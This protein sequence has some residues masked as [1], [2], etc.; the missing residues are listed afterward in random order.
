M[1][2]TAGFKKWIKETDSTMIV[3]TK[4]NTRAKWFN[5]VPDNMV[6]MCMVNMG[7]KLSVSTFVIISGGLDTD[8]RSCHL[9]VGVKFGSLF[10][11]TVCSLPS[12]FD[13]EHVN[14]HTITIALHIRTMFGHG[15][16]NLTSHI[17][18]FIR[19][20]I[21]FALINRAVHLVKGDVYALKRTS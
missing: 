2:F 10:I 13:D 3:I 14:E 5:G 16:R 15:G 1:K 20:A 18:N 12:G 9:V 6:T 21:R 11:E 4:P 19:Q 7:S 17:Y 8:E